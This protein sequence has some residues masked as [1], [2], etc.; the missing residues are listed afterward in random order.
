M[1]N[2]FIFIGKNHFILLF[3]ILEIFSISLI[4]KNNEPQHTN[5]I[6]T[7]NEVFAKVF[8]VN[9][10]IG[11]YFY[12]SQINNELAEENA[13]LHK[14]QFY[15][16]IDK[17]IVSGSVTDTVT[18]QQYEYIVAKV[19]NNSTN[20]IQ[21]YITLNKGS[22]QGIEANMAVICPKGIVGIVTQVS[23]NF[24][25]VMSVLHS[26]YRVSATF[27][28]NTFFGSILWN[29]KDYQIASLTEIP[30]HVKFKIMI[31]ATKKMFTKITAIK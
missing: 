16:K 29:G 25:T 20:R 4:V 10:A 2:L 15:S 17:S 5:Y 6:S 22:R 28:R 31:Y 26:Q 21:N 12:L 7:S 23:Q 27:K 19:I 14:N 18:D 3:L 24:S 30:F 9:Q 8:S 1:R 13:I 11:K